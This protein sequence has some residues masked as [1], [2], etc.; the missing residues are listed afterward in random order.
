MSVLVGRL[1]F[2]ALDINEVMDQ[3]REAIKGFIVEVVNS[4]IA[5]DLGTSVEDVV[6]IEDVTLTSVEPGSVNVDFELELPSDPAAASGAPEL[7]TDRMEEIAVSVWGT[8]LVPGNAQVEQA[9]QN[10]GLADAGEVSLLGQPSIALVEPEEGPVQ[11]PLP[12]P[13]GGSGTPWWDPTQ[14]LMMAII[15]AGSLIVLALAIGLCV[16]LVHCRQRSKVKPVAKGADSGMQHDIED[17][18]SGRKDGN[19]GKALRPGAAT[20]PLPQEQAPPYDPPAPN[21]KPGPTPAS[22]LAF[23]NPRPPGKD[24]FHRLILISSRIPGAKK[25]A[26]AALSNCAVGLY[27]W[28]NFTLQELL[29][30]IKAT[31]GGTRVASIAV[32]APAGKP[33]AVGLLEGF[34]TTPEKLQK[35]AELAQFWKMLGTQCSEGSSVHLLSCR[36]TEAPDAGAHLMAVLSQHTKLVVEASDDPSHQFPLSR[37]EALEGTSSAAPVHCVGCF[38]R[39]VCL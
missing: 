15:A 21:V 25:I 6:T 34:Q 29:G 30:N 2:S 36:V 22:D 24:R 13:Q 14:P 23:S 27:D 20:P 32:L 1:G 17:G 11:T 10:N 9:L 18:M 35:K 31:L 37:S 8:A 26:E 3:T 39:C 4:G 16:W 7:T 5:A 12:Q 38:C 19:S 28:K 33:G